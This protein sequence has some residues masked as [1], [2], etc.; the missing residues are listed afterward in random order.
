MCLLFHITFC[1]LWKTKSCDYDENVN[2][3]EFEES[4]IIT[5]KYAVAS[6]V[7]AKNSLNLFLVWNRLVRTYIFTIFTIW[8][9]SDTIVIKNV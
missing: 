3:L 2:K 8:Y 1:N 4:I 7:G 9:Q 5:K 6:F